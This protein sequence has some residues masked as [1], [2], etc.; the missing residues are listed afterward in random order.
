MQQ[1]YQS[2]MPATFRER[3]LGGRAMRIG[4]IGLG[5][6]GSAMAASLVKAGHDV[7]VFNRSPDKRRAL[8]E[9]GAHEATGVADACK[10]EAVITMLSDDTALTRVAFSDDGVIASLPKGA[11]HIS[12]STVSVELSKNLTQ[13]HAEARQRFIAA[14]VFGRPD[15]AAA[16][17]LFIVSAG[18][19][20]AIA[21]CR[22]LFDALGQKTVPIGAEPA[23]ANLVKLSG[24]FLLAALIEALGEAIALVGKAGIDRGAYVDLLTSTLFTAPPYKTYGA[25]IAEGKFL[26]AGFAAPLGLKDIRL[27]LAAAESLRVPMPLGSLLHDRFLRLL[28]QQG[29]AGLDWAALGGLATQDA[30]DAGTAAR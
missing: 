20:A 6:M 23:W 21:A 28:S 19:P 25:L 10:G 18:D 9:L 16:G 29:G 7:T 24:N 11:I 13:A 30:G 14:P 3:N 4:F 8:L 12:M 22:P 5:N 15:M 26:P 1:V 27:A 2:Q 17:K